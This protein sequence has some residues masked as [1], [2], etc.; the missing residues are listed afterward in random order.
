MKPALFILFVLT[1][2]L[3][4]AFA[5]E[6]V[7]DTNGNAI[8][9]GGKFYIMQA[10]GALGGGVKYAKTDN[11]T[12]PVAVPQDYIERGMPVKFTIKEDTGTG[13]IFTDTPIDIAFEEKPRCSKS[14]KWVVVDDR[15]LPFLGI[16]GAQDHPGKKIID[17]SFKIQNEQGFYKI[18]FCSTASAELGLCV[19]IGRRLDDENGRHLILPVSDSHVVCVRRCW[20][21]WTVRGVNVPKIIHSF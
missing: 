13:M 21:Q 14:S 11:S 15:S 16:G 17:G 18:V 19:N 7:V 3:P 2:T 5:A 1:T 9:P 4:L 20:C 8:S 12:C 6:Q 10:I